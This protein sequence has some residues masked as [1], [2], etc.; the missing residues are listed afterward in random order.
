MLFDIPKLQVSVPGQVVTSAGLSK[1]GA[2]KSTV[3][4]AVYKPGKASF[5]TYFNSKPWF[6]VILISSATKDFMEA[7]NLRA[8]VDRISPTGTFT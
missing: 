1:P 2:D 4:R 8:M 6:C 3:V 7:T 5:F